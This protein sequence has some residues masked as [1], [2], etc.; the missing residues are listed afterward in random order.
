V[1]F[2][3]QNMLL[4]ELALEG[5]KL[6]SIDLDP[7][8]TRFDLA[9]ELWEYPD[10]MR[11]L[12]EY[13]T[14][15]FTEDTIRRMMGHY[16]ALLQ[17]IL[18]DPEQRIGDLPLLPADERRQLLVDWNAT[19]AAYPRHLPVHRLFEAQAAARPEV[20]AVAYAG[21]R[22][23]YAELNR[24]ANQLAHYLQTLGVGAGMLVGIYME[25]GSDMILALLA[26]HKAGGAYLPLDPA[27]PSDRLAF[28]VEDSQTRFIIAQEHLQ[29]QI[30]VPAALAEQTRVVLIDAEWPQ[31]AGE[32]DEN[33]PDA[34]YD[35]ERLAYV[36]YTSGST[37][38]PKGVQVP[39]RALVNFL[40]SMQQAPGLAAEDVLLSV[41]TLS[42]DIAGLE[43]FLPL[44]TGAQVAMVSYATAAD[45]A[46]L[47]D[48]LQSCGATVMQAT[49]AT[50]R[51]LISAGWQGTPG[52]KILCGGEA[53]PGE[54]ANQLL[55]RCASLWN[56]YGP[57]E[58]TIWSTVY[59][60][61]AGQ[62]IMPIGRPI[63]NT[64]IYILDEAGQPTPVGVAGELYIG[65]DGV[66]HG[67]LNRPELTAE[68]FVLDPFA[69]GGVKMYRT[70]DLAR[71]RADGNLD[72]LGRMDF[73]VKI[74]GFRIELGEIEAVLD[75]HPAIRQAVVVAREDTPGDPR[76]VGY[77][78]LAGPT[79]PATADL[80]SY[81]KEKLP[82]YMVPS[83]FV[84]VD[85]FP[86]TPNGKVNRK[87]LPAPQAAR[88]ETSVHHVAPRNEIER[89]VAAIWQTVLGVEKVGVTDNFFDLGGHSLLI[90]RVHNE[91]RRSFETNLTIAQM[92]QF[93]TVE[94]LA[95]YLHKPPAAAGVP[96]NNLQKVQ[97]RAARQRAQMERPGRHGR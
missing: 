68:K 58:T 82:D 8:T 27:F 30:P 25:R 40:L 47:L 1:L 23:S 39:Q 91:V 93:P 55:P 4:K 78:A 72:F 67:Y 54:L 42:F 96:A 46:A 36:L 52:L 84:P 24:R 50:W 75:E 88:V 80:R 90:I 19:A 37:G 44:I 66:A 26:V 48:V 38:R 12:V 3:L 85:E 31:I 16:A 15:L 65:G 86:L 28:M 33:L 64:Q 43:I 63:A 10:R 73:Q 18:D 61:T 56:M 34:T 70:G 77:L 21:T 22:V 49:P 41:T 95:A 87:A 89:Q 13:C 60:V 45:G 57:T 29:A 76:L 71:W 20:T 81:L 2:S 79:A 32:S 5:V 62:G 94:A 11:V 53:M 69:G 6:R 92:F 17:S 83:I 9:L 35:P 14:D 7:D 59:Q 74:R 51:L 97:D